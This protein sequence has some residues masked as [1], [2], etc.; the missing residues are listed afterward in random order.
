MFSAP[1]TPLPPELV[2][3]IVPY[4]A[5]QDALALLA[6]CSSFFALT[7]DRTLWISLL[8]QTRFS[9]TIACPP[10]ADLSHPSYTLPRL[11]AI[12]YKYLRREQRWSQPIIRHRTPVLT[13]RFE[14]NERPEIIYSI[15]GTDIL[16]LHLQTS[17]QLVCWNKRTATQYS[18]PGISTEAFKIVDISAPCDS[19]GVSSIALIARFWGL[20]YTRFAHVVT[21]HHTDGVP[22]AFSGTCTVVSTVRGF[23]D[24]I[25]V[26]EEYFGC[27]VLS[28]PSDTMICTISPLRPADGP[29]Q[30]TE[31][32]EV[33]VPQEVDDLD[34][35]LCFVHRGHL[36][37]LTESN[38][39][40][41][42][43][44][45]HFSR[46]NVKARRLQESRRWTCAILPQEVHPDP[47]ARPFCFMLPSIPIYGVA[48]VFIR[49]FAHDAP[50]AFATLAFLP[51]TVAPDAEE[52]HSPLDFD[53][54][55]SLVRI[56]GHPSH[57]ASLV[58]MDHS[59][60]NVAMVLEAEA[61][62]PQLKLIRYHPLAIGDMKISVHDMEVPPSI[63]LLALTTVCIDDTAGTIHLVD[64]FSVLTT[65][66]YV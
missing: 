12:A 4:L 34:M 29:L 58:W 64:N 39:A 46:N 20:P 25:F 16:L 18:L 14:Q 17:G 7:A 43:H 2:L 51:C 66:Y 57:D 28:I 49:Y 62:N 45:Q 15:Q 9:N 30:L 38:D 21:I 55:C 60:F 8:T 63:N 19:D 33:R 47:M 54:P 41:V 11:K 56:P 31:P 23:F 10:F 26:S 42:V 50:D 22:T 5:L 53:A 3:E 36:Y 65:L 37:S 27:A 52:D 40:R 1:L 32:H 35:T 24:T 44:I 6:T 48:G 13:G 59:G 61:D